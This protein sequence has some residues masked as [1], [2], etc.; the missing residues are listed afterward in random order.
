MEVKCFHTK[1]MTEP[2]LAFSTYL[3]ITLIGIHL[4]KLAEYRHSVEATENTGV[5][6]TREDVLFWQESKM[7]NFGG[8][9]S[10]KLA[11]CCETG[12]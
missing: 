1:N 6:I 8:D 2:D 7:N 10:S 4:F 12:V 9:N 3:E 5:V 11:Y